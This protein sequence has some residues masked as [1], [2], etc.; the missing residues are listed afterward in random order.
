MLKLCARYRFGHLSVRISFGIRHSC[1]VID[2]HGNLRAPLN[3]FV[4]GEAAALGEVNSAVITLSPS[5]KPSVTS[6]TTPSLIPFL[7][8]T[9]FGRP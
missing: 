7:I 6:V 9:A 1:F 3:G 4:P 5:F 2:I 8:C